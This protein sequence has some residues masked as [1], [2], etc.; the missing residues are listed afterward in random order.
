MSEKKPL[1]R[2]SATLSPL[3]RGEG[4]PPVSLLPAARGEGGAKRRMRGAALLSLLLFASTASAQ[5]TLREAIRLAVNN[6]AEVRAARA[7]VREAAASG[8]MARLPFHTS[9]SVSTT[10]GYATGVPVAILGSIPAI[11]TIEAHRTLY[12]NYARVD[13]MESEGL[14]Q[15]RA[16]EVETAKRHAAEAAAQVYAQLAGDGPVVDAAK[17]RV[18]AYQRE[19]GRITALKNEGR[20]TDLDISRASLRVARAELQVAA[21]E[22]ARVTDEHRLKTLIGLTNDQRLDVAPPEFPA[23][24]NSARPNDVVLVYLDRQIATMRDAVELVRRP[25]QPTIQMQTQYSRLFSMYSKYYN[26]FTPNDASIGASVVIPLWSGGR[27]A[28]MLEHAL[29]QLERLT[30]AREQRAAGIESE[31]AEAEAGLRQAHAERDLALRTRAVAQEGLRINQLLAQ[32]GRGEANAVTLSEAELADADE[33]VAKA[34]SH[35][36][37]ATARL[38]SAE[39]V[40]VP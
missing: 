3:R 29:A 16:S 7:G 17:R 19:V 4:Q 2:P 24:D 5:L 35:V 23:P 31:I 13:V 6:S 11:A 40:L 21:A 14:T 34:E 1:T 39:G 25:F 38:L 28:A 37:I 26:N 32:E 8:E 15:A 33:E 27:R 9:A 12:D 10:P 36:A 22:S 20:A 30:V 18:A